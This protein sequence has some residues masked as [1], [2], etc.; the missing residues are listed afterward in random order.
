VLAK[1]LAT[2]RIHRCSA[3]ISTS[4]RIHGSTTATP[5]ALQP[6]LGS[7]DAPKPQ[8]PIRP[9]GKDPIDNTPET[10]LAITP[11]PATAATKTKPAA[12]PPRQT[13]FASAAPHV[14]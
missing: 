13:D 3:A 7:I 5:E 9:A 11:D 6:A 4:T 8:H 12:N 10:L 1:T 14:V 2:T